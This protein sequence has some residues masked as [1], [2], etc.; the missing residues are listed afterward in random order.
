M[1]VPDL[2]A[3]VLNNLRNQFYADR[4]REFKRAEELSA[5]AKARNAAPALARRVAGTVQPVRV[6]ER[7][8]VEVLAGVYRDLNDRQRRQRHQR[9]AAPRAQQEV[10]L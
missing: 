2:I 4:V 6:I 5:A 9:R 10:L 3:E 7:T 1:T 8:D